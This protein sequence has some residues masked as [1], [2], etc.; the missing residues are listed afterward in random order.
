MKKIYKNLKP[1]FF[2]EESLFFANQNKILFLFEGKINFFCELPNNFFFLLLNKFKYASRFFRSNVWSSKVFKDNAYICYGGDLYA[3]NLHSK[4]ISKEISFK[5]GRGPLSFCE[6]KDIK[7]FEDGIYFGEY[8]MN[9][10]LEEIKIFGKTNSYAW[11]DFYTFKNEY[12]INHIHSLIPDKYNNCVWILSGDFKDA[13][14]IFKATNNFNK[15]EKVIGSDQNSRG[16]IAFPTKKGLVYATDSQFI[17]NTI[18]ILTF[19]NNRWQSEELFKINGPVTNG[20][21]LPDFY[22]FSTSTEPGEESKNKIKSF[23]D[24]KPGVGIKENESQIILLSK[25]LTN[26][27]V[28]Y[29]NQKDWLPY[30]LFQFG[31]IS[32]PQGENKNNRIYAYPVACKSNDQNTE[33]ID[34]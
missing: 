23:F 5:K 31:S 7:G 6:I 2:F 25:D 29:R 22:V 10:N 19:E 18:R 17:E 1:L 15:I 24:K 14:A 28:I 20:C 33:I 30:R 26:L 8:F 32:F 27:N 16:V 34:F 12:A 21:E 13:A 4:E 9:P 3:I 11:K